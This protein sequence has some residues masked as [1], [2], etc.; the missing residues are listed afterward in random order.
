M[1][2]CYGDD[3]AT[4]TW[5]PT[6]EESEFWRIFEL[7]RTDVAAAIKSHNMYLTIYNLKAAEEQIQGK[8]SRYPEF[9]TMTLFSLQTTFFISFGR[10]FDDR[11]D[12]LSIQKLIDFVSTF[13][14]VFSKPRLLARK[15]FDHRIVGD[16]PEWLVEYVR[17]AWE[18]ERVDLEALRTALRPHRDKFKE[19]YD[20]IRN[21]VYAHRSKED[22][23][24][25][26]S[27]F[28][29]TLVGDIELI[30][31]FLHTLLWAI[32]EM[33]CDGRRPDLTNVS[34]YERYVRDLRAETEAFI[35]QLA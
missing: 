3:M 15:R 11:A 20:P 6:P 29:R 33:A 10:V 4:F 12:S 13:P 28:G 34:D 24:A 35:R 23:A 2:P 14:P 21:K 25:V 22:A 1:N 8:I 17:A 9:W 31:R 32:Q 16:D 7:V 19:I 26:Y 5:T 18:P 27:L 30:L